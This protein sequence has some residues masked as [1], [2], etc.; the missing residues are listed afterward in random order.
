MLATGII[1]PSN[2]PWSSPL[3]MVPKKA[4]QDWRPCGDY[5]RLNTVTASDRYPISHIHDFALSLAPNMFLSK[6]D[7]VRA[8]YHIPVAEEDIPKTAIT[9]RFGLFEFLKMPFG[10]RNVAQTFQRFMNEVLR[11]ISFVCVYIDDVLIA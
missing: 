5:R 3:H 4:S 2:S 9:T 6:I 10:L 7:L 1:R 8:Y 11:S